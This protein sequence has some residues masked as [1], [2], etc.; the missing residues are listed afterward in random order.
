MQT[1]FGKYYPFIAAIVTALAYGVSRTLADAPIDMAM[2]TAAAVSLGLFGAA[3]A[4]AKDPGNYDHQDNV[5]VIWGVGT[6]MMAAISLTAFAYHPVFGLVAVG[7]GTAVGICTAALLHYKV[8][9]NARPLWFIKQE[10]A[11]FAILLGGG[12][13]LLGYP[14]PAVTLFLAFLAVH[15]GIRLPKSRYVTAP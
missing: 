10:F 4:I 2:L 15:L 14:G 13:D 6:M 5:V 3:F 1:H 8:V 12:F 9:G 7:A 11:T